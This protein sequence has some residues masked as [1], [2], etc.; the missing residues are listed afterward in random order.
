MWRSTVFLLVFQG[1]VFGYSQTH[2]KRGSAKPSQLAI[3][4]DA[5][6]VPPEGRDPR[7]PCDLQAAHPADKNRPIG[8][9]GVP[10]GKITS[11]AIKPCLQAASDN[12][13]NP[14]YDFQLGRAYWAGKQYDAALDAFLKAQEKEYAPA[15]FYL[16]EAYQQ[17]LV[18]GE[19]PD[20][21]LAVDLYQAAAAE[22]FLPAKNMLAPAEDEAAGP[23]KIDTANGYTRPQFLQALY[24][25]KLETLAK[26]RSDVMIYASGVDKIVSEYSDELAHQTDETTE[27]PEPDQTCVALP[28]Q[29]T[30]KAITQEVYGMPE[31]PTVLDALKLMMNKDLMAKLNS[32]SFKE[33]FQAGVD[34]MFLL[35]ADSGGCSSAAAGEVMNNLKSFVKAKN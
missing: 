29:A 21:D 3:A 23:L 4:V 32:D 16:G 20:E 7:T 13:D 33:T 34:D 2:A 11:A 8:V 24:E 6:S 26:D 35:L 28:D 19:K 1:A 31:T 14:R 12:P 5:E 22:G 25:G 27:T 9:Q 10:D 15:Y 18:K 30:S 17:G